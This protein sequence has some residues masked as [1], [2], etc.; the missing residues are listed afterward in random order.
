MPIWELLR[1]KIAAKVVSCHMIAR[2]RKPIHF[3]PLLLLC[4]AMPAHAGDLTLFGAIQREGKLTLQSTSGAFASLSPRNFGTFGVRLSEGRIIG[5][6]H[7]LS[8]SPNFISS[9]SHALF[10]HSN[11]V[12]QAPLPVVHPYGTVGL[13]VVFIGGNVSQAIH[14]AKFALNYG[15]GL[16]FKLAGPLGAQIGARGYRI[17]GLQGQSMNVLEVSVG[18]VV[19]F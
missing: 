18:A 1:T 11:F 2:M 5:S 12:V 19:F 4:M 15:G 9:Q 8:Y 13:G 10:Y 17:F 6:E 3:L 7:T 16:K 14:G